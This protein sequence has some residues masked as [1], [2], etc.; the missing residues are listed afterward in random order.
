MQRG[1]DCLVSSATPLT[2]RANHPHD[3]TIE[4]VAIHLW[5]ARAGRFEAVE[6][7][8]FY[9]HPPVTRIATADRSQNYPPLRAAFAMA[10]IEFPDFLTM[11]ANC[12]S[13]SLRRL[14]RT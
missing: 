7:Q 4:D 11:L 6:A 12:C 9:R 1:G 10:E 3:G 13:E 14:R 2:C 8:T 5:L